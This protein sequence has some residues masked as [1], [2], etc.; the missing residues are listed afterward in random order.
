MPVG[1][2]KHADSG[3]DVQKLLEVSQDAGAELDATIFSD[4]I[5]SE[6]AGGAETD[7]SGR[8]G[9]EVCRMV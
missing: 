6:N 7:Q 9:F 1:G 8:E 4:V 3:A 2:G 5:Q